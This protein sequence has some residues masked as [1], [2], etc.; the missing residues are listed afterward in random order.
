LEYPE[1]ASIISKE[2]TRTQL[3]PVT[4]IIGEHVLV[5]VKKIFK[6]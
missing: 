4:L 5:K 6:K 3:T 2:E 1:I